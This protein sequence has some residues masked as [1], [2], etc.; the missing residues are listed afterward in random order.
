MDPLPASAAS[1][2]ALVAGKRAAPRRLVDVSARVKGLQGE[3]P[4]QIHDL[5]AD[6]ALISIPVR[7][8]G[9]EDGE[10]LGPA[11]QFALLEQHFRDSF[12]LVVPARGVVMEARVVRM[13][14]SSAD[15]DEVA[16]GCCFIEPLTEA[17]QEK[18][19]L[20]E[21]P[22][23][24]LVPWGEGTLTHPLTHAA[25][26]SRPI[27]VL[28]SDDDDARRGPLHLGPLAALGR[29]GFVARLWDATRERVAAEIGGGVVARVMR[30]T[31]VLWEA[32]V[33][34]RA[35][36]YID[37]PRAG[38]EILLVAET[39]LPRAVRKHFRRA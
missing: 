29:R 24:G 20:I 27:T 18:L 26:P 31:K 15:T 2:D 7:A 34:L 12:D 6:G 21:M 32:P 25:D 33:A 9:H 4:A 17:Q 38:V 36:R 10:S 22:A 16:L 3:Y 13:V 37:T 23:A 30:G 11:D 1:L 39:S 28:L 5:S 14:V 35:T 19:G 8:L